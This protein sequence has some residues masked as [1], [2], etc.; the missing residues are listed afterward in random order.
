MDDSNSTTNDTS[1]ATAAGMAS[2]MVDIN[3]A[4]NRQHLAKTSTH[5]MV[6]EATGAEITT[7]GRYFENADDATADNPSLHLYIEAT[8]QE[9]VDQAVQMLERMKNSQVDTP[10]GGEAITPKT[11]SESGGGR[12]SQQPQRIN[13]KVMVEVNSE[14]GF[15]VRA[16][17]IGVGGENMK[18]IQHTTGA[19]VQVRGNGPGYQTDPYEPMHLFI[20]AYNETSLAQAKE[21]CQNLVETIYAQYYEFK[22]NGP[23]YNNGGNRRYHQNYNGNGGGGGG[24]GYRDNRDYYDR[25]NQRQQHG[26]HY[27]YNRQSSYHHNQQQQYG[28]SYPQSS[29]YADYYAQYY[30]YYGTYPDQSGYHHQDNSSSQQDDG[31]HNVPPPPNYSS[32][33]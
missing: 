17:L 10:S 26:R 12:Y 18:Y 30:Q 28:S 8:S 21:Y 1:A 29:E 5:S 22:E 4:V 14:R 2:A 23:T 24:G 3:Q 9:T 19:K 11:A 27:N 31:Y 15:N 33:R 13:D 6:M 7:R 20:T 25:Y 32:H 16:K